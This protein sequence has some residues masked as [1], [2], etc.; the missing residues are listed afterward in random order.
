MHSAKS[1]G[2]GQ[3]VIQFANVPVSI[4]RRFRKKPIVIE[5]ARVSDLIE[6]V[7]SC[8]TN[9]PKWFC[10][11]YENGEVVIT[12]DRIFVKTLEGDHEGHPSDWLIQ[13]VA[14]ELYPCKPDI[15]EATYEPVT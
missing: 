9:L 10:T 8:W 12:A 2:A 11:A 1:M 5:A 13:G 7:K 6:S 3:D 14:G 4:C 15:F